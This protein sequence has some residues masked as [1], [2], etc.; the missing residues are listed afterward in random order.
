L[1]A[2]TSLVALGLGGITLVS[3]W[4]RWRRGTA[5]WRDH[6]LGL[7]TVAAGTTGIILGGTR[8]VC[9]VGCDDWTTFT[10]F[11]ATLASAALVVAA[12]GTFWMRR[13]CRVA[14][15]FIV[16]AAYAGT[17]GPFAGPG[18]PGW[19]RDA[20]SVAAVSLAAV[21]TFLAAR[22]ARLRDHRLGRNPGRLGLI[23]RPLLAGLLALVLSRT[24]VPWP[25]GVWIILA[26]AAAGSSL[27]VL[28][29]YVDVLK[30]RP[31]RGLRTSP[32]TAPRRTEQEAPA[33]DLPAYTP[34]VSGEPEPVATA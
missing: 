3:W 10:A 33:Q 28:A 20:S 27:T 26:I 12:T 19:A 21:L 1:W 25:Q 34:S 13:T 15:L 9:Q 30:E 14:V 29:T 23:L 31:S 24:T 7:A 6:G 16:I 2:S 22:D 18:W 32:E 17:A 11:F 4:G 8:S 5:T